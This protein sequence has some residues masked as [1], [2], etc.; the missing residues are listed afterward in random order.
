MCQCIVIIVI[1]FIG[2]LFLN[3]KHLLKEIDDNKY[4]NK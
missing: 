1:L 2:T 4:L 3:L